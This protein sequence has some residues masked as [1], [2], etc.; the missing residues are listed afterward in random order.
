MAQALFWFPSLC[1]DH[2]DVTVTFSYP[3]AFQT[4]GC[5]QSFPKVHSTG[6]M[7]SGAHL[8]PCS[9][10]GLCPVGLVYSDSVLGVQVA[11]HQLQAWEA[12]QQ[13]EEEE[14]EVRRAEQLSDAL[15]QQ[16]AKTM[17]EEGYRP[18]VGAHQVTGHHSL[19]LG[20]PVPP[21]CL[22]SHCL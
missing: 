5:I 8:P 9:E 22:S 11:E 19:I 6:S 15:L 1:G 7:A 21:L 20:S 12:A 16:E 10:A 4:H 3:V 13:A 18:K 17:A 2:A 14:E